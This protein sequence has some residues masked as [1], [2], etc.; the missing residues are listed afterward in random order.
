MGLTSAQICTYLGS[1]NQV[2]NEG[3]EQNEGG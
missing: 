1:Q 3:N 2:E